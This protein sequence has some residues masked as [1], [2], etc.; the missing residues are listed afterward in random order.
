MKIDIH[1]CVTDT[2][3]DIILHSKSQ[4]IIEWNATFYEY[5]LGIEL[6][7]YWFVTSNYLDF[8]LL[9]IDYVI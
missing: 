1:T 3:Y 8:V 4:K 6:F 2:Y 5:L 9:Y 7:W